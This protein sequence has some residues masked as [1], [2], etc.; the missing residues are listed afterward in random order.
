MRFSL[1]AHN[2]VQNPVRRSYTC[3]ERHHAA[4]AASDCLTARRRLAI[5]FETVLSA[6]AF[7]STRVAKEWVYRARRPTYVLPR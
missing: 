1:A 6:L 7:A 3:S 5:C 2:N 4:A